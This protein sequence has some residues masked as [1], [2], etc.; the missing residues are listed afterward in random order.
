[1]ATTLSVGLADDTWASQAVLGMG[2]KPATKS[3]IRPRM[4]KKIQCR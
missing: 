4:F 2:D 1:M 3:D